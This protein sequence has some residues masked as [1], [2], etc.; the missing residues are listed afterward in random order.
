MR[1]A[2]LFAL[3]LLVALS[4]IAAPADTVYL[5]G[6]RKVQGKVTREDGRV[7]VENASGRQAFN[8]ADVLYIAE[9]TPD[10]A[11][12]KPEPGDPPADVAAPPA[13]PPATGGGLRI[14]DILEHGIV[15]TG[16]AFTIETA[17]RPESVVFLLMR[18]RVPGVGLSLD[19]ADEQIRRWQVHTKDRLRRSGP[20]W[21][22]PDDFIRMRANYA[23][24]LK[25]IRDDYLGIRRLTDKRNEGRRDRDRRFAGATTCCA[26]TS[27]ASRRSSSATT[28]RPTR[29][30]CAA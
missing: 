17:Q 28:I 25:Q 11:P 21:I 14:D 23:S 9:D 24:Q 1:S 18:S 16:R 2:R 6:G 12:V 19:N 5:L 7:I 29:T 10:V 22:D 4:G 15:T 30:S 13:V 8:A 27:P 26:T 20:R 3:T